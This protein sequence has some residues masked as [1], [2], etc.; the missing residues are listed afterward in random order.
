MTLN[1]EVI[2]LIENVTN[3]KVESSIYN[4]E[5]FFI[6]DFEQDKYEA[7]DLFLALIKSDKFPQDGIVSITDR[8]WDTAEITKNEV[9]FS[10]TDDGS[11][12]TYL[13]YNY[14]DESYEVDFSDLLGEKNWNMERDV[15]DPMFYNLWA[16][17]IKNVN[18]NTHQFKPGDITIVEELAKKSA[19]KHGVVI[20][21][22]THE[23]RYPSEERD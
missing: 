9:S 17:C 6:N 14:D 23:E 22:V 7:M 11:I 2:D 10:I 13:R 15:T 20:N 5:W 21:R 12:V 3:C 16:R 8:G 1:K 19:A 4:P 18:L